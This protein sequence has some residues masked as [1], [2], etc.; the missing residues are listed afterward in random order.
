MQKFKNTSVR[1]N[2]QSG[3]CPSGR[4]PVRELSVRGNV[5]RG[6]ARRGSVSRGFVL[7]EVSAGE[8]SGR[9]TVLQSSDCSVRWGHKELKSLE[10]YCLKFVLQQHQSWSKN[11][12]PGFFRIP[13]FTLKDFFRGS[14]FCNIVHW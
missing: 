6:S 7:G 8:V 2:V 12:L 9:E 3:K 10:K 14:L 1:G 4:C 5:R 13:A 11:Q